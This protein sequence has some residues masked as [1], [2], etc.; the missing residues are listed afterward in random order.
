MSTQSGVH[1]ND[2][3]NIYLMLLIVATGGIPSAISKMISQRYALG[4]PDEAQRILSGCA[5]VWNGNGNS[6]FHFVICIRAV[7]CDSYFS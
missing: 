1:F 7:Y 6:G 5:V 4:R 3:N 2:A